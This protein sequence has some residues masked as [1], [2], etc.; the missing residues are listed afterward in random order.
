MMEPRILTR[1][2]DHVG[3]AG[4]GGSRGGGTRGQ[5]NRS[6]LGDEKMATP[7]KKRVPG[8]KRQFKGGN[9]FSLGYDDYVNMH[10]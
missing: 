6:R 8:K 7:L 5:T 2:L 3:A 4:P 9:E 10:T 1:L